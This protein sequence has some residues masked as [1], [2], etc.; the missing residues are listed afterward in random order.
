MY[1]CMVFSGSDRYP[2]SHAGSICQ[3]PSG[4]LLAAW[5]AGS[6]EGAPDSVTLGSRLPAGS[7]EWQPP[8]VWVDVPNHASGNPRVFVGPGEAVWLICPANYGRWCDGGTRLFF[9]RSYDRGKS[10]AKREALTTRRRILGKNKP[11]HV[12]PDLWILPVEYEGIGDVAFLRSADN[13]RHWTVID[14]PGEGAY[15]D[16]PTLVQLSRGDLLAYMRSWEGY[17]YETRSTDLGLTW[18]LPVPTPLLN[19]NSGIDMVRSHSGSL[20]LAYNPVALGPRGDLTVNHSGN[21]PRPTRKASGLR[22]AGDYELQRVIE[23]KEPEA[24]E[25]PSGYLAWGPRT[26]LCLAV[27]EDEGKTW[28]NRIVLEEGPGE[29]SY[30]AIIEGS[31]GA[32]HVIYTYKRTGMKYARVSPDDLAAESAA[33]PSGG[34]IPH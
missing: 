7:Q 4:D 28:E 3:L 20:V 11:L 23:R 16:Q 2:A 26:P 9:T 13:G 22:Q 5:Y 19:P 21:E 27:S 34:R 25:Y 30:P 14:R 12:P 24:V 10:W 6:R 17:I 8:S 31:D 15:L 29:F 1:S 32:V 18:S 33:P